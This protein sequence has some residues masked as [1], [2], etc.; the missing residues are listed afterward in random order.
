MKKTSVYQNPAHET[1][2]RENSKDCNTD[3]N[4]AN[5][6][7]TMS[8]STMNESNAAAAASAA[9]SLNK[10]TAAATA[11][12]ASTLE[13]ATQKVDDFL[14]SYPSLCQYDTLRNLEKKT[15]QP[16]AYFFF[17][18]VSVISSIV[19]GF[20]GMKLGSDLLAFAYPAY[21]SLKAIDTADTADDIQWLTYWVVFAIFSIVEN[22]MAFLTESIPFYYLLKVCLFAWLCHPKFMGAGLVYKQ[23]IKPFVM[24][25]FVAFEQQSKP[26]KKEE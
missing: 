21:M 10:S 22:V 15:G 8:T 13:Q 2:C 7:I 11:A 1:L 19:Y 26:Q 9:S 17:A 5:R 12:A 6:T 16:K 23:L 18:A 3:P 4:S 14:A 20:G 24:P 25:Y